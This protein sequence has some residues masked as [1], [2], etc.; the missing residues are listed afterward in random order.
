MAKR[1]D[2][3]V[4]FSRARELGR[5]APGQRWYY[6]QRLAANGEILTSTRYGT[7]QG[8]NAALRRILEAEPR[9]RV[10]RLGPQQVVGWKKPHRDGIVLYPKINRKK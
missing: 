3:L 6:L 9:L 10:E 7:R 1:P 4:A 8:R 2:T 5:G